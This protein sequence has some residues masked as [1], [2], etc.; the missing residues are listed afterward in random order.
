[1]N[2]AYNAYVRFRRFLRGKD[3]R[4]TV[5]EKDGI[6]TITMPK[7]PFPEMFPVGMVLNFEI[8][9]TGALRE[10]TP[11]QVPVGQRLRTSDGFVLRKVSNDR[12]ERE[13]ILEAKKE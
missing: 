7:R 9:P 3:A 13:P 8:T 12:W 1:M 2:W 10:K 4:A 5:T 6:T 11:S